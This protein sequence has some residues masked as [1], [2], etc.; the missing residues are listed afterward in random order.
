MSTS[1]FEHP[2]LSALLGDPKML[3]LFDARHDV[4]CLLKFEAALAKAQGE[5]G[6]IPADAALAITKTISGFSADFERLNKATATNGVV[7]PELVRQLREKVGE[8]HGAHVHFGATSQ[9]AIDT[10]LVIRLKSG[11]NIV[12]N[13]LTEIQTCLEKLKARHGNNKLMART[14]MQNARPT[15][16]SHHIALWQAPLNKF[17]S[18]VPQISQEIAVLQLGGAIGD[19]VDFGD[20]YSELTAQMAEILNL[21]VPGHCWHTDRS[22]LANLANLL[23]LITSSLGKIGRDVALMNLNE[24]SEIT[25]S[26]TG[27]SS[28]MPHKQNP[29]KAEMLVTL[30]DYNAT[31]LPAMHHAMLH[32]NHRSG[33]AWTLEWMILP[34]MMM[35]TAASLRTAVELL[36]GVTKFGS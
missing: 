26:D 4:D 23:S 24:I 27:S 6:I 22:S 13:G 20:K 32:E 18:Q 7:V 31:Q 16:V 12:D 11:L 1:P 21:G 3:R 19:R 28:V 14:R 8:P 10:S 30:A 35:A 17:L 34:Q 36:T 9:D 25:L 5:L 33:S 15:T 2:Y 29:V